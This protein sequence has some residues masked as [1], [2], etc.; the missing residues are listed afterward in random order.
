VSAGPPPI[1]T[2]EAFQAATHVSRET[3][4]RLEAYA[5]LLGRW[6]PAV[7]LVAA[8]TLPD[9]WRRHMLDSA[10]L[11][12]YLPAT[13]CL[14]ADLGSG[15]G[16]PGLVLAIMG[17]GEVELVEADGRKCAFLREAIRV[18]GAAARVR[19]GRIEVGTARRFA[20]V[21]ARALAPLAKLLGYAQ[22]SLAP[23]GI[24]LFLKGKRLEEELTDAG[25]AWK[26]TLERFPSLTDPGGWVLRVREITRVRSIR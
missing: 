21:T 14:L 26:M 10:Q 16:F 22:K 2:P 23:S 24:A 4:D 9:L 6:Q 1:L 19:E 7:N 13:P 17:A 12:P 15:A 3:L 20:V 5:A 25:K 18:S 8:S 11:L